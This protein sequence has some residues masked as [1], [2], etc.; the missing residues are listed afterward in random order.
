MP[1][2]SPSRKKINDGDSVTINSHTYDLSKGRVFLIRP[3]KSLRQIA[4]RPQRLLDEKEEL[5][6]FMSSLPPEK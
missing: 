1:S 4:M 6:E 5:D 2:R 3:D